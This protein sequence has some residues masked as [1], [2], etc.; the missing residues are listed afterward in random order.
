MLRPC[1][2]TGKWCTKG[3]RAGSAKSPECPA[4]GP[5]GRAPP[6]SARRRAL[7]ATSDE[8]AE[9]ISHFDP[10]LAASPDY[11]N[12]RRVFTNLRVRVAY[13]AE[14]AD[15]LVDDDP[16]Y[17]ALL[18]AF[19]TRVRITRARCLED[20]QACREEVRA[21]LGIT[22]GGARAALPNDAL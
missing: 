3:H 6:R 17:G 15:P 16:P 14:G 10:Q 4:E 18:G 7:T 21:A 9:R 11:I 22:L 12:V 2:C 20:L 5:G 13:F 1:V 19:P 8:P